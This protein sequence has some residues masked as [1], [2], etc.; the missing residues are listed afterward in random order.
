MLQLEGRTVL[1]TGG[2]SGIG[3]GVVERFIAEGARVGVLERSAEN[4]ADLRR[5]GDAV[6]AIQG[7]AASPS[8]NERAVAETVSAFGRLDSLV[9]C[10]GV[11]DFGAGL[12]D[13]S[14]EDLSAAFDELMSINVKGYLLAAKAAASA[15][16]E[17]EGTIVLTLST[18]RS[19]PAGEGRST[20][21]RSSPPAV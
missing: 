21:R 7:D 10:A 15:L 18:P 9:C 19:T 11:W 13:S 12:L 16:I 5:L 6:L 20:P 1:V 14:A 3:L 17:S 8:D 4:V 2:G